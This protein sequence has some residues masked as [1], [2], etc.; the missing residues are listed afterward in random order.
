MDGLPALKRGLVNGERD[1]VKPIEKMVGP[2]SLENRLQTGKMMASRQSF[3]VLVALLS[4]LV[5][6]F[7][8]VVVLPWVGQQRWT[9]DVLAEAFNGTEASGGVIRTFGVQLLRVAGVH[10]GRQVV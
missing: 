1:N 6:V 2:W 8:A 10:R 9:K 3:P 5:G 7:F 4:F